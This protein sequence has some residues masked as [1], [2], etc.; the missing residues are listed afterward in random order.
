MSDIGKEKLS[1]VYETEVRF[2]KETAYSITTKEAIYARL[3]QEVSQKTQEHIK[4]LQSFETLLSPSSPDISEAEIPQALPSVKEQTLPDMSEG[5]V[6]DLPEFKQEVLF[7]S[8][9]S[10]NAAT[11][12]Q[13]SFPIDQFLEGP[14]PEDLNVTKISVDEHLGN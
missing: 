10:E 5:E 1:K 3:Y 6:K 9:F 13:G 14:L 7:N 2:Q 11:L 4:L 8:E 12:E